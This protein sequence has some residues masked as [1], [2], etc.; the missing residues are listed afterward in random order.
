[1]F[2]QLS[3]FVQNAIF[4]TNVQ[5]HFFLKVYH[6]F[7]NFHFQIALNFQFS[8]SKPIDIITLQVTLSIVNVNSKSNTTVHSTLVLINCEQLNLFYLN[9]FFNYFPKTILFHL[10]HTVI[11]EIISQ[12]K[13]YLF[14]C[15]FNFQLLFKMQFL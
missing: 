11:L 8:V 1:M 3:T 12:N 9:I 6:V 13:L 4:V 15:F 5:N 7:F 2:L 14:T 10:I